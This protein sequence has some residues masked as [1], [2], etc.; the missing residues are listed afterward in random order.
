[1]LQYGRRVMQLRND[2]EGPAAGTRPL[3]ARS[4]I[5]STLLGTR[6]LVLPVRALVRAG[7][8][9]GIAEGTTRVALSRM[10][11]AG[12][13]VAEDGRYRLSGPL[14]E[15]S[16]AQETGRRPALRPWD[17]LWLMA[18]VH[19]DGPR[20]AGDRAALRTALRRLDLAEWREGVWLRPDNLGSPAGRL[21][22][23]AAVVTAQCQ[24]L[25]AR[26]PGEGKGGR[27]GEGK[28][29]PK[30]GA[31]DGDGPGDR[32]LAARLWDLEGWAAGAEELLA[33]MAASTGRGGGIRG[34]AEG[35]RPGFLLAAAV[36]RQ[37]AADPLLPD[38]LLPAR[39][40]G[41]RLRAAYDG[42]EAALQGGLR[43]WF[44]EE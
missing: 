36:V 23:A 9:F 16:A 18:V 7:E 17:G 8:L 33:A 30:G 41:A 15:R 10:A 29:G 4:V 3:S 32:E 20:A 42:F 5:A 39:W 43:R 22:D 38:E 34:G 2:R 1:M 12:E 11:A 28:D 37:L 40:P 25:E 26:L 13:L 31:G 44:R 14:L 6:G 35:L 19:H 24:W 27:K 21:P